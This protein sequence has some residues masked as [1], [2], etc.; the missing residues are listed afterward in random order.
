[1]RRGND[2]RRERLEGMLRSEDFYIA[3]VKFVKRSGGLGKVKDF[4]GGS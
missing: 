4:L 1:M 3:L 2:L